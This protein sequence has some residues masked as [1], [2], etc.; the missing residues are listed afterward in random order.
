ML[1][2]FSLMQQVLEL[3]GSRKPGPKSAAFARST[4][5]FFPFRKFFSFFSRGQNFISHF[6]C[7]AHTGK[8]NHKKGDCAQWNCY[9]FRRNFNTFFKFVLLHFLRDHPLLTIVQKI[10]F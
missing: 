3:F 7:C 10:T 1:F 5:S 9:Q 6:L 4:P 2:P 8:I